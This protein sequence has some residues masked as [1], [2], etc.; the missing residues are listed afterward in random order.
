MELRHLRLA[1]Y[2]ALLLL[3]VLDFA[4]KSA[5]PGAALYATHG[6]TNATSQAPSLGR[7]QFDDLIAASGGNV[8]FPLK[9]LRDLATA[10]FR[11]K[12]QTAFVAYSRSLQMLSV[13]PAQPR[14]ILAMTGHGADGK[15][16][17]ELPFPDIP[18][19]VAYSEKA[20]Q[21]EV[22]S[23][24]DQ[25]ARYE[26]QII[27]NYAP[28]A[29]P[30]VSYANRN[31]CT[32]CHQ[33]GTPL[34]PSGTNG[35]IWEET[36]AGATSFKAMKEAVGAASYKGLKLALVSANVMKNFD[37]TAAHG[38]DHQNARNL[39]ATCGEGSV[40]ATCRRALLRHNL[41]K[42]FTYLSG[43]EAMNGLNFLKTNEHAVEL[44]GIVNTALGSQG[45]PLYSSHLKER[46]PD[47]NDP[48]KMSSEESPKTPR[49]PEILKKGA[50]AW[51]VVSNELSSGIRYSPVYL[52]F[53]NTWSGHDF[54]KIGAL[55][56][57]PKVNA[58]FAAE[59][60]SLVDFQAALLEEASGQPASR[61][62]CH[63]DTPEP[64]PPAGPPPAETTGSS[65]LSLFK[66]YCA[67]CHTGNGDAPLDFMEGSSDAEITAKLRA[68]PEITRRLD[69]GG[70]PVGDQMP[71]A[72]ANLGKALRA[73]P[74][75]V[76]KMRAFLSP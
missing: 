61:R 34:F 40:A 49:A 6:P 43:S 23:Y 67:A 37:L 20:A 29:T 12:V 76:Q 25:L 54:T 33:G 45:S 5:E 55:F 2:G 24:N 27:S 51:E 9:K 28:N 11:L 38:A 58:A 65:G 19:F 7:S 53:L 59:I 41:A 72:Y 17:Q 73:K 10:T 47:P 50:T 31:L 68:R 39:I 64:A 4:C 35:N 66:T 70:T 30:E 15:V 57:A 3:P 26:F 44:R 69:W 18:M 42:R 32:Q 52:D 75:D 74:S 13:S 36:N 46:V 21:L 48:Y 8:P 16:D 22:I 56:A 14:I 60:F 63:G 71:P 62:C 1:V